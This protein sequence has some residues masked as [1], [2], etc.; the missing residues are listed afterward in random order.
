ILTADELPTVE[1][2][3]NPT[4]AEESQDGSPALTNEPVFE[5]EPIL[6]VAAVD[7][8]TAAE[9]IEKIKVDLERLPFVIDPIDSLRPGG[10][11]A[12]AA[13]NGFAGGGGMKRL[14]WTQKDVE[15]MA[16]GRFPWN[17]P[18]GEET[19][20]GDVDAGLKQADFVLDETLFQ[21][22]TPHQP[23]ESRS[24]MAYWQNGKLFLHGSTQ[25]VAQTVP[26]LARWVGLDPS[27]IVLVSEYCGGGFGSKALAAHSMAVPAML[28]RKTG[29]PVMM[30]ISR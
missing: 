9:A 13:G 10:P 8:T 27:Q 19:T 21:Q 5:G 28:S 1:P 26:F 11:D 7:E 15:E 4:G 20:V 6:A 22:S 25:S 24:A 14:K 17:A 16:L 23:L 30:R 12:R 2:D 29:R 3:K 18:A